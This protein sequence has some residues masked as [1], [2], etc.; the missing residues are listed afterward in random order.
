LIAPA[1]SCYAE[2]RQAGLATFLTMHHNFG[3][4]VLKSHVLNAT[5]HRMRP[6]RLLTPEK[7]LRLAAAALETNPWFERTAISMPFPCFKFYWVSGRAC[8]RRGGHA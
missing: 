6:R 7:A 8:V 1:T 4:T 5:G 2:E 3:G